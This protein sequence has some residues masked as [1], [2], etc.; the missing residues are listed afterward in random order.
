MTSQAVQQDNQSS[1]QLPALPSI[2]TLDDREAAEADAVG[3]DWSQG[4]TNLK[5]KALT[6]IGAATNPLDPNSALH[7]DEDDSLQRGTQAAIQSALPASNTAEATL[8]S[9]VQERAV[10]I[11]SDKVADTLTEKKDELACSGQDTQVEHDG[12]MVFMS[13]TNIARGLYTY[14][15]TLVGR[16]GTMMNNVNADMWGHP[17]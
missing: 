7:L 13:P 9:V 10:A 8:G 12:C 1:V 11:A 16:F 14:G 15:T 17:E 5:D 4:L 6:Q 2:Q 3:L